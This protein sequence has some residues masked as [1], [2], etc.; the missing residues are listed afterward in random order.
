MKEVLDK[1][2]TALYNWEMMQKTEGDEGA[3]WA[4]RFEMHFYEFTEAFE[5]WYQSLTDKP[6]SSED[7]LEREEV[8]SI[9]ERLPGPLQLNFEMEIEEMVD[10]LETF[11]F[12]D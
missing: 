9:Q 6:D 7:L 10:G 4:E 1:L 5:A 3:D 11:R 12:D 8:K 2:E